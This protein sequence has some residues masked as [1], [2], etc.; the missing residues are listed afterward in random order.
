M[1]TLAGMGVLLIAGA[2][3]SN[4]VPASPEPVREPVNQAAAPIRVL[5]LTATAGF[6]HDSIA[7]ARTVMSDLASA[8][9]EFTVT[10]TEELSSISAS[11]LTD[12][13]VI[14]FALT[15]G[16]LEFTGEQKTAIVNFV[17]GGGG[18]LGVHSAT[19]TLYGWPDYGRLVGAYFKE[20][21]WTGRASVLVEDQTHPATEGLGERFSVLEEFY[22][23]RDNPRPRVQVL[24]RLDPASVGSSGDYPLAWVQSYGGGRVY[25]NALG[26]FS[27]TWNDRRFQQ[28]LLGAIRWTSAASPRRG[29]K[30]SSL[31]SQ[32][33]SLKSRVPS[34]T[35]HHPE[36]QR[37]GHRVRADLVV[38]GKIGNRPRDPAHAIVAARAQRHP[39]RRG[40]Q[41]AQRRR[42]RGAMLRHER[43]GQLCVRRDALARVADG[44]ARTRGDHA[45][46]NG[47]RPLPRF[48]ER[49]DID[50]HR[51]HLHGQ[52]ES[53]AQRTREP[54][55]ISRHLLRR[56][57][58]LARR[59][60]GESART[61]VHRGNQ[62]EAGRKRRR[63]SRAGDRD[64]P[65]F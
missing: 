17:G 38:A 7:T 15:S 51:R 14:F 42:I 9:G 4:G 24:L 44:L 21:P 27:D 52:I 1:R 61:R 2:C 58:A 10:T 63:A 32:V 31:K 62:H 19:D 33:S 54:I 53:I 56:A 11:R 40:S 41:H 25:Y 13:D 49:E 28:Q 37:L 30:V 55:A 26:H 34:T 64:T 20:H 59:I 39:A 23:F 29:G 16:E 65:F 45:G 47:G 43:G 36:L 46:A 22:T 60:A 35:S 18:F 8:G 6:R 12:Y 50:R 48:T 5:M 3:S 57:P